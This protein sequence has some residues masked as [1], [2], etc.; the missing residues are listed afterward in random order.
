MNSAHPVD[1]NA[2]APGLTD[3]CAEYLADYRGA[4]RT[5]V[6][7]GME[8]V[9]TSRRY[10]RAF[11]GLLGALYCAADAAS[12]A[13]G[14]ATSR[15]ALVGV[16]GYGRGTL[17]L[18]SD[19]DVLFL[20]DDPDDPRVQTLAS[21]LLYPLWDLG[22][23]I[24][25]A[26]RTVDETLTLAREDIRTTTTLLDL[27]G[28]A[29]DRAL[30][31]ELSSAA[32]R[33]VLE[34]GI[35]EFVSALAEDTAGRHQ[36]FG[37]SLYLLE[38]EVKQGRGGLRDLDILRWAAGARWGGSSLEDFVRSGALLAREANEL[39][40]ARELLW[41]SRNFLHTRAGKRQDRLTFADQED[42][43]IR[44]GFVDGI[45]L[46]VEQYMQAYYRHA[47]IVAVSSER[48]LDRAR[49]RRWKSRQATRPLGDG[50][51]IFDGH[52][53]LLESSRLSEDPALALRAYRQVAAR[54]LP[55]YPF[56][57][58][59]IARVAPDR[60]WAERL[61]ESEEAT[62][63]FVQ[64]LAHRGDVPSRRGSIVEEMHDVGLTRAMLPE[65]RPLVGR[66]M[67]D[68]FHVYTVDVHAIR[69]VDF[70]RDLMQGKH[71]NLPLE[72]RLA[73]ETPRPGPLFL[74]TFLHAIGKSGGY[75]DV[76]L[77]GAEMV[78][79]I[80]TRL[81]FSEPDVEHIVFLVREQRRLYRWATRRDTTDP[82]VLRELAELIGSLDRL[83]DLHLLTV[84]T[85]AAANPNAMTAWKAR[86]LR[87]L[88]L[89]VAEVLE[90]GAYRMRER[91]DE[92]RESLG[93]L[94]D[95]SA[96]SDLRAYLSHMPDRYVLATPAEDI[97]R[98]SAVINDAIR[99]SDTVRVEVFGGSQQRGELDEILVLCPDKPGLLAD[100]AAVFAAHRVSIADAQI[101]TRKAAGGLWAVDIFRVRRETSRF[102]EDSVQVDERLRAKIERD[103]CARLEDEVSAA[104]LF[105]RR[106][107][108]P[109]WAIRRAPEVEIDV[110]VDN[111][112]SGHATVVDVFSRDRAGVVYTIATAL[113]ELGL[114][115]ELAKLNAEGH[116]VADIFYVTK[117][118]AKIED[119]A[120][121]AAVRELILA[122]LDALSQSAE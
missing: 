103:L 108:T 36:R 2:L 25:H 62:Q 27:R 15:I 121:L 50:T 18:F 28:I 82:E 104:E 116:R 40:T 58:D 117:D 1:L 95:G 20:C 56:A 6:E 59:A 99:R 53:T 47:E 78:G 5:G 110:V 9:A 64:L 83:R 120:A 100:L 29:G 80:A 16:G 74:A 89:G 7:Q 63:L 84:V 112:V 72:T 30:V 24:G 105:A 88:Y 109:A 41:R 21:G 70:L 98:H 102:V 4:F 55:I 67:H 48:M 13:E 91:A 68:V 42:I 44:L 54:E 43:A 11:D 101:F 12:R 111:E 81:G 3:T 34:P 113:H 38:P 10:A 75:R 57:R 97:V 86:V 71:P 45:V 51:A 107:V 49:P 92:L 73:S 93:R 115:I 76:D 14:G 8:G 106:K 61:R 22:L 19:L 94:V 33:S 119:P 87:D 96:G 35:A 32:R 60:A 26:V 114:S 31:H 90:R 122:R 85:L 79:P 39:R 52:I 66:V 65:I 77:R 37:G 118:G 46:A 17:G 23:D 69:S